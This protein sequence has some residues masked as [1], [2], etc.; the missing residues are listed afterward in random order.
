MYTRLTGKSING[1][2]GVCSSIVDCHETAA[3]LMSED[4][5]S[6]TKYFEALLSKSHVTEICKAKSFDCFEDAS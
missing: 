6:L 1:H 5:M 4:L 2:G 3:S